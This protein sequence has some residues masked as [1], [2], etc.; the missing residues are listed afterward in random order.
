MSGPR[1]KEKTLRDLIPSDV[2]V[3]P[4]KA[5]TKE[6]ALRELLNALVIAGAADL[7][8]EGVLLEAFLEKL[9]GAI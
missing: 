2:T 7:S 3:Q 8:R 5:A 4:L 6:E 1:K 9:V